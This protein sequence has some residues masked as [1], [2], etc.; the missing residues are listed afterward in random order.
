MFI[1]KCIYLP[2]PRRERYLKITTYSVY[3]EVHACMHACMCV[4]CVCMCVQTCEI[5]HKDP[6]KTLVLY[7][8]Q[9]ALFRQD[10]SL[11]LELTDL[12]LPLKLAKLVIKS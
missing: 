11:N 4:L 9:V 12:P 1:C 3:V 10:L 2:I 7:N 6:W 8:W 5:M